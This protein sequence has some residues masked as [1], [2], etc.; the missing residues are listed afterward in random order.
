[1]WKS[2][3]DFSFDIYYISLVLNIFLFSGAVFLRKYLFAPILF[4]LITGLLTEHITILILNNDLLFFGQQTNA[5]VKVIY[6]LIQFLTISYFFKRSL[7][8]QWLNKWYVLLMVLL[9]LIAIA[10]YLLTPSDI[11]FHNPWISFITIPVL[12]FLSTLY[13][14]QL[15]RQK[16]GYAYINIGLF[17]ILGSSMV[18]DSTSPFYEGVP[19]EIYRMKGFLLL[20]PLIMMQ[21]LFTYECFLFFKSRKEFSIKS[22]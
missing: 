20:I 15:L 8:Y 11:A 5:P 16:K 21:F 10:P 1:M 7:N 3:F 13:F 4:Y 18:R 9:I 19:M 22:Q 14:L 6:D 2:I 17:L 12:L